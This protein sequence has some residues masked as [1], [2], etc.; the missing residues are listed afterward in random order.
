[1]P[2]M[3]AISGVAASLNA[4][5]NIVKAM[6]DLRDWSVVQSKVIELQSIILDAQSSIFAVNQERSTLVERISQLEKELASAKAWEAEKQRY[7]LA[8]VGVNNFAYALKPAMRGS[9]PP[10]YLCANCYQQDKKSILHH[11]DTAS[12]G[13]LLTCSSCNAKML[14]RHGY[15]APTATPKRASGEA[16]PKCQELAFRVERS[17]PN[18]HLGDLGVVDRRMK[19]D[20]CGFTEMRTVSPK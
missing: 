14:I 13:D 18:V 19:C 5:I 11:M 6:K 20:S 8:D 12:M 2:D 9:E 7:E 10:H 1:M 15:K 3:S 4:A 17:E 16:C